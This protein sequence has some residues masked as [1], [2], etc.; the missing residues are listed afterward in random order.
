[1]GKKMLARDGNDSRSHIIIARLNEVILS[2][3]RRR[4]GP[5]Y[6]GNYKSI[7]SFPACGKNQR[8]SR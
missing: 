1:V 7:K 5:R 8:R 4:H 6:Q 2:G 3:S